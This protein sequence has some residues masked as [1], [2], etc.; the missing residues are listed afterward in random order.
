MSVTS[1]LHSRGFYYF[2]GYCQ[3]IHQ[4]MEDLINLTNQPNINVMEIGFNAGHSSEVFLK[5][6]N[7]LTV[8]SFDLGDQDCSAPA[9]EYID[10]TYPNRHELI[11]GDSTTTVP[12]YLENNKDKKF[13]FIFIDGGKDYDVVNADMVNCSHFAH[14][15]TIVAVND[16]MFTD[17]WLVPYTIGP[18][19]V[20]I[21]QLQENKIIELNR[22]SY[23]FGRGMSWGK[24]TI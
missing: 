12:I 5:N 7:N 23:C 4:Q 18:T 17:E 21:E 13:D 11:I 14:K 22:I 8:V 3:Q 16:T 9:K 19:R 2:Q 24:Y 6:N 15:D 1:F 20:W 10:E